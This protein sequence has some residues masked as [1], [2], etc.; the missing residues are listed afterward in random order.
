[1]KKRIHFKKRKKYRLKKVVFVLLL[2]ITL[3][4][5]TKKIINNYQNINNKDNLNYFLNESYGNNTNISFIVMKIFSVF[6]KNINEPKSFLT[7]GKEKFNS[8]E[9]LDEFKDEDD[10]NPSMY[11]KVTTY[12]EN[13]NKIITSD[14]VVYIYNTHQLETYS[15]D[16]LENYNMTPNVMMA[17][18]LLQE[19]LNNLGVKTIAEDTNIYEFIKSSGLE[20]D[21]LYK[22]SRLFVS[23][24]KEKYPSLK[25]IIDLHR[26]SVDRNISALDIDNKSFARVLFVL[27]TTNEKY[28]ENEKIMKYLDD[29]I[30]SKY[31]NLSRGIYYRPTPTWPDSYNQDL[32]SEVILI[33]LGG[34]DNN[35]N[36]VINTIDVLSEV[37]NDYIKEN[38]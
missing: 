5:I 28:Q 6:D 14:P 27:G 7:Y 35:I 32:G 33:E 34:V 8:T 29:K 18:Y 2:F 24:A 3:F 25:L 1:M 9:I 20:S 12:I 22:A 4:S 16:G 36:E 31:N 15:N 13:T 10:Y 23:N 37:I 21:A 38:L 19:K 26:D 11:E 30:N 17:S